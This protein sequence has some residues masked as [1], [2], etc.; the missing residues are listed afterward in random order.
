MLMFGMQARAGFDEDYGGFCEGE[1]EGMDVGGENEVGRRLFL[2]SVLQVTV[3]AMQA[4]SSP[5]SL[6]LL[7]GRPDSGNLAL[8]Q[9]VVSHLSS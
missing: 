3:A 2:S 9:S 8:A 7:G 4:W 6:K 5:L 1:G